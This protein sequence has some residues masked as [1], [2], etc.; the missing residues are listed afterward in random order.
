MKKQKSTPL[1]LHQYLIVITN[2]ITHC[3]NTFIVYST[4]TET[5]NIL[6][7]FNTPEH[8]ETTQMHI[9]VYGK[10]ENVYN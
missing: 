1:P 4:E 2:D 6:N 9:T 7:Q 5:T 8:M 10:D 3:S